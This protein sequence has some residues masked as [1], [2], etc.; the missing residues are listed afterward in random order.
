MAKK[1]KIPKC[2]F[3]GGTSEEVEKLIDSGNNAMICDECVLSCVE[4]LIYGDRV[5]TIE[6]DL[7]EDDESEIQS[8]EGC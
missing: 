2:S 1:E 6:L 5:T 4:T 3:C 8:N 7:G